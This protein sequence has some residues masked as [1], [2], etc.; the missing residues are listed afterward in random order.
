MFINEVQH[1]VGLSKKSIRYYEENGLLTPKRNIS[2]DYRI[3]DEEDIRKLK[4]IKFLRD[5]DVPIRDL[6]LLCEGRITLQDCMQER[7]YR[8]TEQEKNYSRVKDMCLRI[9][10]SN[11]QFDNIDITQYFQEMN[12]L[13]KGG[14]S[15][16]S[17]KVEHSKKI[18]G[19]ALSSLFF[20]LFFIFLIAVISYFQFTEVDKMPMAIYCFLMAILSIPL[21]GI[22][23]NFVARVQEIKG[24]EEDEA[25]KY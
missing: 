7:I 22:V 8:I 4:V 5:L 15:M 19:A 12:T 16:R 3:Y 10:K 21:I 13:N 25:S 23:V 18:Y 9:L 24:G 6:K 11:N 17:G 14:F 2:N 20:G 1:A